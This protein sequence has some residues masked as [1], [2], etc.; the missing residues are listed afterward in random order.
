MCYLGAVNRWALLAAV[1]FFVAFL[2]VRS[3]IAIFRDPELASARKRLGAAK[4]RA[5][6]AKEDPSARA[7][8]YREAA[9]IALDELGRTGLA[10]SY[11][12]RADR[13]HPEGKHSLQLLARAMSR[14]Q[15][16]RALEK[17]LWRRLDDTDLESERAQA[18]V[19][20]LVRLYEGPLRRRAT[21]SVLRRLWDRRA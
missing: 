15:R 14:G 21:A 19:E 9:T 6:Q 11:A 2:V 20:E 17:L 18:I 3:R 13:A 12:R 1:L 10:A 4:Q 7:A 5:R 8:A 16:H